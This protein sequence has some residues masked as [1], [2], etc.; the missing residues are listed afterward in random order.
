M[1]VTCHRCDRSFRDDRALHQHKNDSHY[2]YECPVCDFDASTW[3]ELLEHCREVGCRIV[4][5]GCDDGEGEHWEPDGQAYRQHISEHNVCPECELHFESPSNLHQHKLSHRSRIYE[6]YCCYRKFKTYD[7]MIIHLE[8]GTCS[9]TSEISLNELA[10]ECRKWRH[11][12]DEDYRDDMYYCRNLADLHGQAYPYMCP[13]CDA[14]MPKLS[15]LFQHV[16][17]E[18]CT[19]TLD[20]NIIGQL[21]NYLASRL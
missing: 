3:D 5:M 16:E 20:D 18:S 12:I 2:H 17:S 10:A 1:A 4:C 9:D 13:T 14:A 8:R 11:F 21:R 19:Q 15:S 6:C 7:G